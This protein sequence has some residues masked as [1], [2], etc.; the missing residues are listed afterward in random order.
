MLTDKSSRNIGKSVIH[1]LLHLEKRKSMVGFDRSFTGASR[2]DT[3]EDIRHTEVNVFRVRNLSLFAEKM[4]HNLFNI[5]GIVYEKL[6]HFIDN[7]TMISP[8]T[9]FK[10]Q[11]IK[12]FSHKSAILMRGKL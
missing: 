12:M 11:F 6:R 1:E 2:E 10:F 3:I 7:K 4:S 5:D 9:G 8:D